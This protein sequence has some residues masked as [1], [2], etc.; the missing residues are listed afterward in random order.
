MEPTQHAGLFRIRTQ[1]PRLAC[2]ASLAIPGVP[3][4]HATRCAMHAARICVM[5]MQANSRSCICVWASA[6]A[7]VCSQVIFRMC[8]H[9]PREIGG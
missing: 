4:E 9:V 1:V 8:V 2:R 6:C 7:H 3:S 5:L